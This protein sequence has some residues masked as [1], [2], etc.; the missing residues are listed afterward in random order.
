MKLIVLVASVAAAIVA[1]L[2]AAAVLS[3]TD[4]GR[5]VASDAYQRV[6]PQVEDMRRAIE[7][8]VQSA[9]K[10]LRRIPIVSDQLESRSAP[11]DVVA[12]AAEAVT[13]AAEELAT[14]ATE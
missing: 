6:E 13:E 9:Q 12:D 7:P 8:R 1:L 10:A 4:R 5:A 14:A 11:A 2:V 3:R